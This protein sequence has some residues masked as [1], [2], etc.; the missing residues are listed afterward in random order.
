MIVVEMEYLI[1]SIA[2]LLFLYLIVF[3]YKNHSVATHTESSWWPWKLIPYNEWPYWLGGKPARVHV[4]LSHTSSKPV[5]HSRP[6]GG[7]SRSANS[8]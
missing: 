5:V 8:F 4:P 6:W 1:S 3:S 2:V 7:A